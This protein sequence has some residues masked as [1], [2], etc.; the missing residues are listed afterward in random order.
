MAQTF[1]LSLRFSSTKDPYQ[2][3]NAT[4]RLFS[5]ESSPLMHICLVL[6]P[7]FALSSYALTQEVVSAANA[8]GGAP[9]L[10][11]QVMSAS[12]G[13]LRSREGLEI[14]PHHTGWDSVQGHDLLVLCADTSPFAH[15][16]M[17]TRGFLTKA[18]A[19]GS[20]LAGFGSGGLALAKLGFLDGHIAT[21]AA[22]D[23]DWPDIAETDRPFE[24]DRQRLTARFGL[25]PVDAL[26]AWMAR[27]VDLGLAMRT[28]RE[29]GITPR[30]I[31]TPQTPDPTL[32]RMQ[33][34]MQSALA[35]PLPL[36][37]IAE[38][39]GLSPKRLR[40]RCAKGLGATPAQVYLRLRLDRAMTLVTQTASPVDEIAKATGFGTP[41]SF[42]RAFRAQFGKTPRTLR[43]RPKRSAA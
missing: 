17:G 35:P 5:P 11:L 42:T 15:L 3:P 37:R 20:T 21:L 18:N 26:L 1:A 38:T 2:V 33:A 25:T 22:H 41:S 31:G 13:P 32:Q 12:Y 23:E 29:L 39:L 28:G 43:A 7:G 16:T 19:A 10:D 40:L 27:D 30:Q 6:F 36:D 9:R 34:I 8:S 4:K 24:L 14:T